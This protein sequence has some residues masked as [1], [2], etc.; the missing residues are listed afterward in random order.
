[1]N[2][3]TNNIT[4]I[5][6]HLR[7]PPSPLVTPVITANRL[8]LSH[9]HR[10]LGL[11]Q[12]LNLE[13]IQ[14]L[15][16]KLSE[17]SLGSDLLALTVFFDCESGFRGTHRISSMAWLRYSQW[18]AWVHLGWTI[19]HYWEQQGVDHLLPLFGL[20]RSFRKCADTSPKL[21]S[22]PYNI[23]LIPYFELCIKQ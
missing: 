12:D 10:K 16:L 11:L 18:I 23:E 3:S 4:T 19:H 8:A 21:A 14:V 5:T 22:S 7:Q 2:C 9:V 6:N 15:S 1:M 17:A 13:V 20:Q